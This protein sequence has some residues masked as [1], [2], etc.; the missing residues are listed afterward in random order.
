MRIGV[1]QTGRV[2]GEL[3][4]RYGEYPP[5]FE[6]L[7]GPAA[8]EF[9]FE[10]VGLVDGAPLPSP[11]ACDGWMVTGSRYGVYDD[12]DWIAPFKAWLR[13]ARGA[14]KPIVGVCF[15][16]Q[17]M[18]EAF[19]G[20]AEKHEG[21]W[22]VGAHRFEVTPV[23]WSGDVGPVTLHSIHQDQVTALPADASVWATTPGCAIAGALYGD[24]AAPDAISLQPHPE[25]SPEF[26]GALI[27]HLG[28]QGRVAPDLVDAALASIR[29]DAENA[30]VGRWFADFFRARR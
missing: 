20:R 12:V 4:E 21:G 13:E 14:G 7:V 9:T 15:G 11:D 28:D 27:S 5:M 26:A 2:R 10:A 8:P 30:R 1:I 18:A 29:G 16:H 25:F 3:A 23:D 22:R 6:A 19:G 17:I 24:P